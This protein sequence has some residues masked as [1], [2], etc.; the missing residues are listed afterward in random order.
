MWKYPQCDTTFLSEGMVY[1]STDKLYDEMSS[2]QA[3]EKVDPWIMASNATCWQ[4]GMPQLDI[5][6]PFVHGITDEWRAT[7]ERSSTQ[8]LHRLICFVILQ[9][10][11]VM[12]L[13]AM[14]KWNRSKD[15]GIQEKWKAVRLAQHSLV[16]DQIFPPDASDQ[17]YS[18]VEATLARRRLKHHM[19]HMHAAVPDDL[20][21]TFALDRMRARISVA[22]DDSFVQND[23][24]DA[25]HRQATKMGRSASITK[26]VAQVNVQ[27]EEPGA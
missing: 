7:S 3:V 25:P 12:L 5:D 19:E 27:A 21:N 26:L 16:A 24:Q 23:K 15:G 1:D 20:G 17:I 22:S 9:N 8:S 11:Q 10:L 13:Y 4:T 6:C 18:V 2:E 14:M